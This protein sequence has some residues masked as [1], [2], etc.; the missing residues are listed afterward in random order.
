MSKHTKG[1]WSRNIKPASKYPVIFAGRN[2]QVA[3]VS[4]A[5]LSAEE[6]EANCNLIAA[7]DKL[8]EALKELLEKSYCLPAHSEHMSGARNRAEAAIEKAEGKEPIPF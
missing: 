6:I 2:T 5:G 7:A 3:V 8:L 1:G 4:T